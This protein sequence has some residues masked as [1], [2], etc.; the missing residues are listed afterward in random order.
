[1][2]RATPKRLKSKPTGLCLAQLDAEN[3]RIVREL[4]FLL[5]RLVPARRLGGFDG[6]FSTRCASCQQKSGHTPRC[7]VGLTQD[8][9]EREPLL[10]ELGGI[11]GIDPITVSGSAMR[12]ALVAL[13]AQQADTQR[14]EASR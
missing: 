14:A 5:T 2:R 7:L 9:M 4:A 12:S 6:R 3:L 11:E 13:A 1:M 8:L 10:L